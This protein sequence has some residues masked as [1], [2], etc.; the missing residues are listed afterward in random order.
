MVQHNNTDQ[1]PFVV[2]TN[3]EPL[4]AR[5]ANNVLKRLNVDSSGRLRVSS[6]ATVISS[7]TVTTVTTAATVGSTNIGG[8]T[9]TAWQ[10][11]EAN[12]AYQC[13]FRRNLVVT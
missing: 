8:M 10:Q 2:G 7:G 4:T 13:G 5:I 1:F 11:K 12:L 6:E 3:D 9:A